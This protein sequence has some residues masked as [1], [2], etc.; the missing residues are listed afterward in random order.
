[1]RIDGIA[2][3]KVNE[4]FGSARTWQPHAQFTG[5]RTQTHSPVRLS[6]SGTRGRPST[7]TALSALCETERSSNENECRSENDYSSFHDD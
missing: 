2:R 6:R 3:V 5:K 7:L 1:L 4:T